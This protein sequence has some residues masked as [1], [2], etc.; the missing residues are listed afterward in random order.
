MVK[1]LQLIEYGEIDESI[2]IEF[3]PLSEK[4]EETMATLRRTQAETDNL[5]I[6]MGALA[7]EE[8]REELKTRDNSPYNHFMANFDDVEAVSYTHLGRPAPETFLFWTQARTGSNI[9]QP[10][11]AFSL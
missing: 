1:I 7:P 8:V 3:N 9:N 10:E 4:S 5:Y 2:S 6:A 11:A